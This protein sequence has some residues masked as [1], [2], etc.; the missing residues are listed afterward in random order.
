MDNEKRFNLYWDRNTRR[1]SGGSP[2]T[3]EYVVDGQFN[4][5]LSEDDVQAIDSLEIGQL[6]VDEDGDT[7][8]RIA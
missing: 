8:E 7:W 5:V 4:G 1:P 3:K 6:H 2:H